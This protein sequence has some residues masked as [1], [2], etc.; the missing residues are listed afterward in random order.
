MQE[1]LCSERDRLVPKLAAETDAIFIANSIYNQ[2][3]SIL[4]WSCDCFLES[5]S[6]EF[7]IYCSKVNA[8]SLRG[9]SHLR[10]QAYNILPP[11]GSVCVH[12]LG[13]IPV[14]H[15]VLVSTVVEEG[16]ISCGQPRTAAV[17]TR[18]IEYRASSTVEAS[19]ECRDAC[20]SF[21][22]PL[23]ATCR[24]HI[25]RRCIHQNRGGAEP[26][27]VCPRCAN[28]LRCNGFPSAERWVVLYQCKHIPDAKGPRRVL[29]RC[30]LPHPNLRLCPPNLAWS[31][32][33][34]LK[35]FMVYW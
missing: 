9:G 34:L 19:P 13:G 21:P 27:R 18:F 22:R 23:P 4:S 30:P 15:P 10:Q 11:R 12:V 35:S 20:C 7:R 33:F 16:G 1:S 5:T 6:T 3:L 28:A 24:R 31:S 14:H 29:R 8:G 2:I 32:H 17:Y 26:E 25:P